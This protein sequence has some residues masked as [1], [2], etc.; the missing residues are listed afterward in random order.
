MISKLAGGTFVI[1]ATSKIGFDTAKKYEKRVKD[2]QSFQSGL[3]LL[4][5]EIDFSMTMLPYAFK[6]CSTLLQQNIAE[7]FCKT[8]TGIENGLSTYE[9]WC[10]ALDTTQLNIT[11]NDREILESFAKSAG[12]SDAET[13]KINIDKTIER[14]K[15]LEQSARNDCIRYGKICKTLGVAS[16]I[17]LTIILI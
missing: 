17:M 3:W 15:I 6:K 7:V 5:S 2:L 10:K 14:L 4:K 11:S 16:G 12:I 1:A 8:A 9:S 13:E